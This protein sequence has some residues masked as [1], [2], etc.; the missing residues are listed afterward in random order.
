MYRV[1]LLIG[2]FLLDTLV[3]RVLLAA[4]LALGTHTLIQ[5]LFDK[6]IE[7]M[8]DQSEVAASFWGL[9][10]IA[11]IPKC[12]SIIISATVARVIINSSTLALKKV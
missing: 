6:Y 12:I 5:T 2:G 3:K 9:L 11:E 10:S 1:F 4:G 8:L 7:L